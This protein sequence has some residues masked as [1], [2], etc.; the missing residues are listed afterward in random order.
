MNAERDLTSSFV[1]K[2]Y[3]LVSNYLALF[4]VPFV[5]VIATLAVFHR[6]Y[7]PASMELVI[8]AMVVIN[9]LCIQFIKEMEKAKCYFRFFL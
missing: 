7:P 8:C 9:L 3:R 1:M 5:C 2:R 6:R 4:G